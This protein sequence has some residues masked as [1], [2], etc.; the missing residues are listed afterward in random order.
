VAVTVVA[1]KTVR[2]KTCASCGSNLAKDETKCHNCGSTNI[3]KSVVLIQ[4]TLEDDTVATRVFKRK[5]T[6][7]EDDLEDQMDGG[8]DE[9]TEDDADT[10][11]DKKKKKAPPFVK[12]SFRVSKADEAEED[13]EEEDAEESD[14]DEDDQ[15]DSTEESEEDVAPL[16]PAVEVG[17]SLRPLIGVEAAALAATLV[18]DLVETFS[19]ATPLSKRAVDYEQVMTNFSA[20]MD[21]AADTWL[22]GGT[23]SKA[24]DENVIAHQVSVIKGVLD[25]IIESVG[26]EEIV[27]KAER[28]EIFK[29]MSPKQSSM[30]SKMMEREEAAQAAEYVDIA[31]SFDNVPGDPSELGAALRHLAAVDEK[32]YETVKKTLAAANYNLQESNIFKSYGHSQPVDDATDSISKSAKEAA[33]LVK[34]GQ[35][36]SVAAAQNFILERDGAKNYKPTQVLGS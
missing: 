36:D 13:D 3:K 26:G 21:S 27:A 18:S 6:K 23:V 7:A 20:G 32:G 14:S 10:E 4:K 9:A 33:D 8:A 15:E 5:S 29:G 28:Y 16:A 22:G 24:N 12:K 1:K 31:K 25:Q 30:L 11:E 34:K 35:F 2:G 19:P 17:K